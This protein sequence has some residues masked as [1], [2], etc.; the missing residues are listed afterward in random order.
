MGYLPLG[1]MSALR[2][3]LKS[4]SSYGS[5]GINRRGVANE[6]V[7]RGRPSKPP[8]PR[9]MHGRRKAVREALTQVHVGRYRAAKWTEIR[10][11]T[12]SITR[13][14]KPAEALTRASAGLCEVIDPVHAWKL[15]AR[16]P[17]Y[18]VNPDTTQCMGR[19][20]RADSYDSPRSESSTHSQLS[21]ATMLSSG[22]HPK[23]IGNRPCDRVAVVFFEGG[24]EAA[25]QFH[26]FFAS[27]HI[28][29]G[30]RPSFKMLC[31]HQSNI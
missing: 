19:L 30:F 9:V 3:Q 13:K 25:V 15:H 10:V 31:S 27:V 16:E 18:P 4:W 8:R 29:L 7:V 1:R 22:S 2:K 24:F 20:E 28:K 11:P 21:S 14:A 26:L 12:W 23:D 17:G 5:A 6:R